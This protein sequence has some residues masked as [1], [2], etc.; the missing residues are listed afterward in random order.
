MFFKFYICLYLLIV[1]VNDIK[2]IKYIK[3]LNDEQETRQNVH[4][5]QKEMN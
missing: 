1:I 5:I 4:S 2:Y 3:Y